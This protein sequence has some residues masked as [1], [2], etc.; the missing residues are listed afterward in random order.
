MKQETGL[1]RGNTGWNQ[2]KSADRF[3][4]DEVV[5]LSLSRT[6]ATEASVTV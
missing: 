5:S 4:P 1:G 2:G 3:G 6:S